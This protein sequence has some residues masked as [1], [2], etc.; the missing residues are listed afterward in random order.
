MKTIFSR[1]NETLLSLIVGIIVYG[2]VCQAVGV[3][4]VT[5][6]LGYSLGLWIG[7]LVAVFCAWHM[8]WSLDR[9]LTLH[10]DDEKGAN[11]YSVR[12]SMIRYV[13]QIIVLAVICITNFANPVTTFLGLLGLKIGA[14]IAPYIGNFLKNK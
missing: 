8:W 3:W 7:I 14:Y 2:C 9:N 12:N 11:A 5:D 4:F 10:A 6:R 1:I 13:V